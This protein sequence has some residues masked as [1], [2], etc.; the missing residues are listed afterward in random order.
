MISTAPL[1]CFCWSLYCTHCRARA[2]SERLAATELDLRAARAAVRA[3]EERTAS[4]QRTATA[5]G[6]EAVALSRSLETARAAVQQRE[7][8]LA[9]CTADMTKQGELLR[10]IGALSVGTAAGTVTGTSSSSSAAIAMLQG[11]S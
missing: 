10:A 4:A 2:A 11:R 3:E 1:Y 8:E 9:R 7:A 6:R 5:K